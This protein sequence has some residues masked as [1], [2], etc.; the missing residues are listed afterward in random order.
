MNK[1]KSAL[2]I[3]GS[4]RKNGFTSNALKEFLG[5]HPEIKNITFANAY[6]KNV[7]PCCACGYC[8]IHDECIYNDM[9]DIDTSIRTV[10]MIIFATPV[11][12][13]SVPS[14]MK[15]IF[16]RMQLYYSSRFFRN[17]KPVIPKNKQGVLIVT[18]GSNDDFGVEVV[19][20]QVRLISS[21]I[22]CNVSKE[23]IIKQTDFL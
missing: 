22:N 10:D 8:I 4:P 7:R 13:L 16:D 2:I 1:K 23:I 17:N 12:N 11:Y 15:S 20:K 3:F 18:C 21:I 9:N 14:P 6:Q 19:K 5:L